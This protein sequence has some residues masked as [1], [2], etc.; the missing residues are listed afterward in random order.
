MAALVCSMCIRYVY[1]MF[2]LNHYII[3]RETYVLDKVIKVWIG[4]QLLGKVSKG[5]ICKGWFRASRI[6]FSYQLS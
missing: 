3:Q 4:I 6:T 5:V 1:L 2:C